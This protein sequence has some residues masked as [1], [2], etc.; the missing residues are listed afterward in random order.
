MPEFPSELHHAVPAILGAWT[1]VDVL[2][3]VGVGFVVGGSGIVE[4]EQSGAVVRAQSSD[5]A[6]ARRD[7]TEI[8]G[9]AVVRPL[10]RQERLRI[11]DAHAV[12]GKAAGSRIATKVGR[13]WTPAGVDYIVL[14]DRADEHFA[15]L[16]RA[17]RMV[18]N[19]PLLAGAVGEVV[20]VMHT[21]ALALAMLDL[22]FDTTAR[23][24][25]GASQARSSLRRIRSMSS[26]QGAETSA[27]SLPHLSTVAPGTP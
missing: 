5:L 20:P 19:G 26:G 17:R 6:A 23:H 16:D 3:N 11:H 10:V 7:E 13:F 12:D 9:V 1:E 27:S 4:A 18:A 21:F 15:I 22:Q 25:I 8:T 2:T 14:E 24:S